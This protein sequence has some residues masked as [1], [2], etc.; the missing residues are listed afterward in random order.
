MTGAWYHRGPCTMHWCP[1]CG[2]GEC[3]AW[4]PDDDLGLELHICAAGCDGLPAAILEVF[5]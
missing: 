4:N 5:A 1:I 3:F 2:T